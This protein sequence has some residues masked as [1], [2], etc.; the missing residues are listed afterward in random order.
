MK[1][2]FLYILT[3]VIS[4]VALQCGS[5]TQNTGN[6]NLPIGGNIYPIGIFYTE[7][8]IGTPGRSFNVAIDTG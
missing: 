1:R 6:N 3:F 2:T 8:I 4:I 5:N 7:I